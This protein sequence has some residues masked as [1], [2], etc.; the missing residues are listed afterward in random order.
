MQSKL[1]LSQLTDLYC[2]VSNNSKTVNAGFVKSFFE[3]IVEEV[4][5]G[6]TV[7]VRGLGTFKRITIEDRESVNVNTG[8]RIVIPGHFKVSLVP[9]PALKELLNKPFADFDTIII[10]ERYDTEKE[11]EEGA[12]D[13]AVPDTGNTE[14]VPEQEP[15]SVPE[16]E[17]EPEPE[18]EPEP[19]SEP[20]SEPEPQIESEPEPELEQKPESVPEPK[21]KPETKPKTVSGHVNEHHRHQHSHPVTGSRRHSHRRH[22]KPLVWILGTVL[23]LLLLSY[24]IWPISLSH[25]L[26]S[27]MNSLAVDSSSNGA[28]PV[29]QVEIMHVD[30]VS[31]EEVQKETPTAETEAEPKAEPKEEVKSKSTFK[32]TAADTARD[33][34]EVTVADTVSYRMVGRKAVHRMESGETLTSVAL[35]YYGT[36]LLWPY[37]VAYNQI[38][39]YN[40]LTVG[41]SL[42]IPELENK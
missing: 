13:T 34:G 26:R 42:D 31:V 19:E 28:V 11:A 27:R 30:S 29:E 12:A 14:S 5:N 37:I 32:L 10:D 21:P 38:S 16:P 23:V 15:E 22:R 36:K 25:L 7:R 9:D 39:N 41:T 35:K 17:S 3:T 6:K 20:E 2:S 18:A 4:L 8:E 40:F 1:N 24:C 33:L